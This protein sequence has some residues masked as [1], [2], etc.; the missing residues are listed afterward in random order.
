MSVAVVGGPLSGLKVDRPNAPKL[1]IPIREVGWRGPTFE[2]DQGWGSFTYSLRRTRTAD[3]GMIELLA[4]LGEPI[5][6]EY[7]ALHNLTVE[8]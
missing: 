6:P 8:S 1:S 3:G 7:L 5:A 2:G 4:P